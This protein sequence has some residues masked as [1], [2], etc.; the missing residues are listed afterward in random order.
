MQE[1]PNAIGTPRDK[2]TIEHLNVAPPW[3][4]PETVAICCGSC[5]SSRGNKQLAD[6]FE[7]SYCV[8][9]NINKGT[10][11]GVVREYIENV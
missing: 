7:T 1:Y 6:W 3:N 10:V 2:A 4:N 5:N 11:A 9:R 8:E